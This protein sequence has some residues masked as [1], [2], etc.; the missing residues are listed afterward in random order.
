MLGQSNFAA[1]V[2]LGGAPA[3]E[4]IRTHVSNQLSSEQASSSTA[5]AIELDVEELARSP[6]HLVEE[7][8]MM[9]DFKATIQP[10]SL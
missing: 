8:I 10:P 4:Q 5:V 3:A 6:L 9:G 2:L 7:N 1:S